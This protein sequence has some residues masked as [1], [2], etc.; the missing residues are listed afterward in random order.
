MGFVLREAFR[1]RKK[2]TLCCYQFSFYINWQ[3]IGNICTKAI[4]YILFKSKIGKPVIMRSVV[5]FHKFIKALLCQYIKVVCNM[6]GVAFNVKTIFQP[7]Y[8]CAGK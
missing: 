6:G 3:Y 4:A 1:C 2:L 5:L 7:V 8:Y